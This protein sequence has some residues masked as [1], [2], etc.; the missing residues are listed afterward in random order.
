MG[1]NKR[2]L[3]EQ[4][5]QRFHVQQLLIDEGAL[6]ECENHGYV[7]D[8]YDQ[9]AA[10]EVKSA[11]APEYGEEEASKLVDDVINDTGDEC[12]GCEK[13]REE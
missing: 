3:E 7:T 4:I 5:E 9:D 8:N 10:N 2:L 6:V 12:P 11:L 13:N 1:A